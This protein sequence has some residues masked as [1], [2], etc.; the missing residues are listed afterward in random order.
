MFHTIVY[1]QLMDASWNRSETTAQLGDGRTGERIT[2]RCNPAQ[3]YETW[4][5]SPKNTV[6]LRGRMLSSFLAGEVLT[7]YPNSQC[8]CETLPTSQ[9]CIKPGKNSDTFSVSGRCGNSLPASLRFHDLS[10]AQCF[11]FLSSLVARFTTRWYTRCPLR[12]ARALSAA[13]GA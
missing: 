3:V 13:A 11:V 4:R 8:C 6:L 9:A 2:V 1:P 10:V 12:S 7:N 5:N